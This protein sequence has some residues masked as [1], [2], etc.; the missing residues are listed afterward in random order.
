MC[1]G[2]IKERDMFDVS[3]AQKTL[4]VGNVP[5]FAMKMGHIVHNIRILFHVIWRKRTI[6]H[7]MSL[8]MYQRYIDG[9]VIRLPGA[10][11]DCTTLH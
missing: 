6:R 9:T 7:D 5:E 11:D 10:A 8:G 1:H 2:W 4:G 3:S